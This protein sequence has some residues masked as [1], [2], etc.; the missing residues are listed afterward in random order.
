[1]TKAEVLAEYLCLTPDNAPW[2]FERKICSLCRGH[3]RLHEGSDYILPYD[4]PNCINGR[5]VNF[6]LTAPSPFASG[7]AADVW[8]GPLVRHE[9]FRALQRFPSKY[10]SYAT[11]RL[12][13]GRDTEPTAAIVRAMMAAD[14]EFAKRMD[15]AT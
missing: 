7:T 5:E 2:A 6:T 4:C 9:E 8:L 14:P 3:F 1:M 10:D 15:E 13:C 11:R 12:M